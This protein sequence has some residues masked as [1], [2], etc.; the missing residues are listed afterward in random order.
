MS[1]KRLE[2]AWKGLLVQAWLSSRRHAEAAATI[3]GDPGEWRKVLVVRYDVRLGNLVMIEPFLTLLRECAPS[4]QVTLLAG[5]ALARI[6]DGHPAVD[7]LWVVNKKSLARN[8]LAAA[9]FLARLRRTGYDVA[10]DLSHPRSFSLTGALLISLAP[11]GLRV[12]FDR[13]P[14]RNILDVAVP[15]PPETKYEAFILADLLRSIADTSRVSPPKLRPTREEL[16]AA[17]RELGIAPDPQD[18]R[19]ILLHP[20]GR[21]RKVWGRDN[22]LELARLLAEKGWRVVILLGPMER[23][24]QP[25]GGEPRIETIR[26]PDVRKLAAFSA[27]AALFVSGDTGPMHLAAAVGTPCLSLFLEPTFHRFAPPGSKH[28]VL[29]PGDGPLKPDEVAEAAAAMLEKQ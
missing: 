12:G 22:F 18:Q 28:R 8:P 9:K 27:C 17:K 10:F 11:A 15:V 20:G 21:G 6:F 7:K 3:P 13:G 16:A 2:K 19:P 1:L 14:A 29:H 26:P 23:D 24:F 25:S 5:T 4:A